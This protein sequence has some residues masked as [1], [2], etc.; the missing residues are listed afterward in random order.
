MKT[1]QETKTTKSDTIVAI[2][3]PHGLGGIAI[4][5]ISGSSAV[6]MA[7]AFFCANSGVKLE[8][9]EHAKM[10]YGSF[11]LDGFV[12]KG[13]AVVFFAPKSFTG[14]TVVELQV[15]GG[16]LIA[17]KVI[18]KCK[19]L[20]ARV[21]DKGEFS[22]RAFLNG[23]ASLDSLEGMIDMI[24]S[25]SEAELRAA[26][27][28]KN[29]ELFRSIEKIESE[30]VDAV[31]EIEVAI[32]YPDEVEEFTTIEKVCSASKNATKEI[33]KLLKTKQAGKLIRNGVKTMIV[34]KPNVGKSSLLNSILGEDRSIVTDI[35]GTTRDTIRE[36]FV[37]DGIKFSLLDTAGIRETN[38]VIESI[39]VEKAKKSIAEADLVLFV[40]DAASDINLEDK[41]IEK[42]T[43][44]ENT[45]L[46][47]NKIDSGIKNSVNKFFDEWSGE[48]VLVSAK[49]GK[50]I[51]TV[52]D[53]M[54]KFAKRKSIDGFV[55]TN[56]RHAAALENA[57]SS[58]DKIDEKTNLDVAAFCI[59]SA[60]DELGKITGKTCS[61]E[62]VKRIFERFCVGK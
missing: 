16:T 59:K 45:L 5:R 32:D 60:L 9:A 57:K 38:D 56:E 3:S 2:A 39:G 44:K 4:I 54:V 22:K 48:K 20:G 26:A 49:T 25:E 51:E 15:H 55:V 28:L 31:S 23:K 47:V 58:L 36:T 35:A 19:S 42:L 24:E 37:I 52:F 21:A 46:V 7:D 10:N 12:E 11:A 29:G 40:V 61:E 27:M 18:E 62:V 8:N 33:E 6:T 17:E 30:L 53:K 50:E 1:R 13:Y 34:G 41:Q 14:E 43:N